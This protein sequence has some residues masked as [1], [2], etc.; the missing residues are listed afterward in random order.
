MIFDLTGLQILIDISVDFIEN[1]GL[2]FSPFRSRCFI[3]FMF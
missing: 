2:R 3:M 1:H